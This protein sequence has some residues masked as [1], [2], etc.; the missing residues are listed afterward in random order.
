MTNASRRSSFTRLGVA[1]L[2]SVL[3]LGW[4]ID[5]SAQDNVTLRLGTFVNKL[6]IRYKGL[7]YFADLIKTK[8]DGRVTIQIFDSGTLHPFDKPIDSVL[9][10]VS[11]ISPL[12]AAGID[13][14]LPCAL[15]TQFMPLAVD[16]SR[17]VD[18]DKEY[19]DI[20]DE[21]YGKIGLKI[22][23]SQDA[24]YDQ[25]WWFRGQPTRV[26][27]LN[28]KLVRSVGPVITHV[29]QRFGGKPVFISPTETYQSAERGVVDVINMGV[30][31]FS[32]WK[33]WA[34]MPNMVRANMF[35]SNVIYAIN[36]AKFEK[37]RPADQKAIL[38]AGLEAA[39]W[40]TPRYAQWID[41]QVGGA[42]MT[43]GASVTNVTKAE[44]VRLINK[45]AEGWNDQMDKA[46]GAATSQRLRAVFKK[47]E[48]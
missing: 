11:D 23:L 7:Q 22:V 10:G 17:I 41:E 12:A 38:D 14:R 40:T 19:D 37:L 3:A 27:E 2:C 31:T 16:W 34:V 43:G 5:A 42:I 28:G 45:A 26:D 20:L 15:I 13:K 30:S 46:C 32:S 9:G 48:G 29:I 44:R 4:T 25:E 39:R 1:V 24:S 36:K 18:L 6:D 47:Y 33:L 35:Y 8:T 21:E